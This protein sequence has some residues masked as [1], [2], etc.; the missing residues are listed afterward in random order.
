MS[1]RMKTPANGGGE[2]H[3][4]GRTAGVQGT[5]GAPRGEDNHGPVGK[6]VVEKTIEPGERDSDGGGE[7]PLGEA[8]SS[9][10]QK[11]VHNR[12]DSIGDKAL[13]ER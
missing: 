9:V 12:G 6:R 2:V 13:T 4:K 11:A 7:G 10:Y 8:A 1:V 5:Y 3:V